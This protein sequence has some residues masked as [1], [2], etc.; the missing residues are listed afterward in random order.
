MYFL[1]L[2]LYNLQSSESR[3]AHVCHYVDSCK[4][5]CC[6]IAKFNNME[7]HHLVMTNLYTSTTLFLPFILFVLSYY[8]HC[9]MYILVQVYEPELGTRASRQRQRDNVI[10]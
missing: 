3:H 9:T 4:L 5:K 2:I 7:Q 10:L 1:K 6:P 8:V